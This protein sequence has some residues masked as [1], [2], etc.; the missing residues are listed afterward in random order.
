MILYGYT[1]WG[2]HYVT[3]LVQLAGCIQF[4]YMCTLTYWREHYVTSIRLHTMLLYGY[5]Y[6]GEHYVTL[7]AG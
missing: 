5:T 7:R 4:F 1:Y 6:L 2:E 3:L